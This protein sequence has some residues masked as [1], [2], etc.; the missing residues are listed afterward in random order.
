MGE[1]ISFYEMKIRSVVF[2]PSFALLNIHEK[3]QIDLGVDQGE[4]REGKCAP[5]PTALSL[6]EMFT[7]RVHNSYMGAT[8]YA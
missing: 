8:M 7:A 5:L 2:N 1:G 3:S 6:N 4:P